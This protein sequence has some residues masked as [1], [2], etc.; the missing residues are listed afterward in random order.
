MEAESVLGIYAQLSVVI[1]G[2]SGIAGVIGHRA[3]GNWL[4]ADYYRFWTMMASGFI[5][6]FQSVLPLILHNLSVTERAVWGWSSATVAALV[7]GQIYWRL[8][9]VRRVG[10]DARFLWFFWWIGTVLQVSAAIV[11]LLN[12]TGLGFDR[13][14]GPY[15]LAMSLIL[16]LSCLAFIRLL[17]V[18]LPRS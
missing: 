14:F 6:L 8:A 10:A 3:T 17:I 13:T 12:A 15:L 9:N 4:V 7:L 11:L 2:L 18:A 16:A 5:L 1:V